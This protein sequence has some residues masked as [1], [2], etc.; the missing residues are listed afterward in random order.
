MDPSQ[1]TG[2][3]RPSGWIIVGASGLGLASAYWDDSWHSTLG[4]DSPLIPPH[5]LLYAS[6]ATVGVSLGLWA[7]RVLRDTRSL[8]TLVRAPGYILAAASAA[9]TAI[10][11]PADAFWHS[12]FGRDAV[13]WS[14]P[15]LLSVI[16]T[17]VLL[18]STLVSVSDRPW[19]QLQIG[20]STVM[21]AAAQILVMEYD[22]NVPQ[23]SE[24]LYLPVALLSLLATGWVIIRT[25]GFQFTLTT[26]IVAY[27]VFRA[28]L[29]IGLTEAG[30]LAPD[31]PLALLG[32]AAVDFLQKLP[33]LRWLVAASVVAMLASI[34]SAVGLSS[35]QIGSILPWTMA[36]LGAALLAVFVVGVRN[37]AATATIVLLL[38]LSFA[39]GT[40][41]RANAHDPGQGPSFGTAA[42]SVRGDGRGELTV[43]VDDFRTTATM[44]GPAWLV[45]RRAGQTI[46]APLTA[47][48]VGTS[49]RATGRMSL[50]Y[51]GLWFVY[52]DVSSSEG[53][54]EVWLPISHDLTGTIN[55]TRSLYQPT[56]TRVWSATQYLFALSLV[57]IGALLMVL[58]IICVRRVPTSGA[59]RRSY[60]SGAQPSLTR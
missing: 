2:V 50:P 20:L 44:T 24:T 55:Q 21:L 3:G 32:L 5:L 26:A 14:P 31:L 9:A 46:T 38:G 30:W 25:T 42:L 12:T 19:R 51:P 56:E 22:T 7:L 41:V 53:K 43:T 34:L 10:A 17:T 23:F 48:S 58:L 37:R 36:V 6:I 8:R 54:L 60:K 52:A 33:R 39:L 47:D 49:G 57:A 35:V 40:P 29:T 11:A 18:G 1:P 45:A 59:T 16:A 15:H 13:L 4:R 28:A 27:I